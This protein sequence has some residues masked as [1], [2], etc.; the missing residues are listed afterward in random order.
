MNREFLEFYDRELKLLYERTRE[1]AE[2]YPN[3]AGRLGILTADKMD[4]MIAGLLEGAAFMAARVQLKLKS[5]FGHFTTELIEQ[6]LPGLLA[7]V[8]AFALARVR[9][10][11]G[12]PALLD[13]VEIP[14]GRYKET[15]FVER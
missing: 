12:N 10:D 11:F 9:P 2:E 15:T 7:P 1:F 4:P 13:G 8:P 14:A 6:L 3:M 5:E